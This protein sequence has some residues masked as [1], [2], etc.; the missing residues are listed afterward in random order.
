M[1]SFRVGRFTG[2]AL[3]VE[4]TLLLGKATDG[5]E[6]STDA[7][8]WRGT[9]FSGS[10]TSFGGALAGTS[11]GGRGGTGGSGRTIEGP[12]LAPVAVAGRGG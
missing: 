3:D 12:G 8:V 5:D 1:L 4:E 9:S 10:S 6:P 11:E 7:L 2:G